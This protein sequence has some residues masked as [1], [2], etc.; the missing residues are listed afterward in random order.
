MAAKT[1]RKPRMVLLAAVVTV[2][3]F[4]LGIGAVAMVVTALSQR[5]EVVQQGRFDMPAPQVRVFIAGAAGQFGW[6][7]SSVPDGP[8]STGYGPLRVEVDD[9]DGMAL[10]KIDGP[11]KPAGDLMELLR[12][13]LP[14][15]PAAA[16]KPTP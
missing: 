16:S 6:K 7:S 11:R 3:L 12:R 15:A 8:Y 10:V 4:V 5:Q 2:V 13:Q 9:Q 1:S 14:E